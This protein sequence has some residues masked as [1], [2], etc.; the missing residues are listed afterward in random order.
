MSYCGKELRRSIITALCVVVFCACGSE[1]INVPLDADDYDDSENTASEGNSTG[2]GGTIYTGSAGRGSA[3]RTGAGG[4]ASTTTGAQCNPNDATTLS[5]C[6]NIAPCCTSD[7]LC[8][9]ALGTNC[10]ALSRPDGGTSTSRDAGTRTTRDSGT[11]T[12]RDAGTRTTRDSGTTTT[13]DSGSRRSRD[14]G[15][16]GG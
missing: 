6:G 8:G 7:G 16:S 3:G 2:T 5:N 10:I 12:G 4:R 9:I 15:S 1:V 11:A 14:S 13:R